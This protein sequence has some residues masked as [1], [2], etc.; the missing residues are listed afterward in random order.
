MDEEIKI[1]EP[2]KEKVET[3]EKVKK[4]KIYPKVK[5]K[6]ESFFRKTKNL[7]SKIIDIDDFKTLYEFLAY[8]IFFGILLNFTAYVI[9]SIPLT[10][11]FPAFG[12]AL[13][14]IEKKA[15]PLL[16]IIIHK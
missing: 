9:F 12:I 16:R 11:G 8:V 6:I 5:S 13:W 1:E 14:F 15:V 7:L 3:V 10:L 2:K 4:P